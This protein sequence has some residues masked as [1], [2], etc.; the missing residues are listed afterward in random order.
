[1]LPTATDT[2]LTRHNDV[3]EAE[4]TGLD[5]GRRVSRRVGPR[6]HEQNLDGSLDGLGH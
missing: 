1:M 4:E 3:S 2:Q 5:L 6:A